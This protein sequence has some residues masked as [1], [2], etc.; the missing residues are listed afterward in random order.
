M[1]PDIRRMLLWLGSGVLALVLVWIS[2]DPNAASEPGVRMQLSDFLGP[3]MGVDQEVSQAEKLILPADTEF[4]RKIYHSPQGDKIMAS[5]VLSGS[6]KRSIHRP[7]VCLPGQGWT[8]NSAQVVPVTL[9][10]GTALDVMALTLAREVETGPGRR[11]TIK[12]IYLYWF[13]GK[14]VTTPYHWRRVFLSSWDRVVR[15]VNHR[16]A[17]VI[18]TSLVTEG[19]VLEGKNETQT[20]ETLRQFTA[21]I[22]P[23]F[24][25][26]DAE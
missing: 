3:Y 8:I 26:R 25:I 4:A 9:Q 23:Q 10:D 24:M 22:A 12:S 20:L 6:E 11:Q 19:L 1:S 15:G 16:W 18:V 17:Y 14:Q 2:P 7:E 21:Q 13:V 5:I